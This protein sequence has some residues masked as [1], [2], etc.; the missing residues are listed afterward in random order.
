MKE[1]NEKLISIDEVIERA[2]KLG[3]DFG[4][5]DPRNRL[6]YYV[7]IGLLPHAK[8]K[9]FQKQSTRRCLS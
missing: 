2:K 9:V 7:K 3:V 4:K 8:R 6:R 5:G 1:K